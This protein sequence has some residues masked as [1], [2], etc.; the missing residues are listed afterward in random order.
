MLHKECLIKIYII[1]KM[2][3]YAR[4][5]LNKNKEDEATKIEGEIGDLAIDFTM[6]VVKNNA[7]LANAEGDL[8]RFLEE[9]DTFQTLEVLKAKAL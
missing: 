3:K 7:E 4:Y 6:K 1:M 8:E 5:L 2:K 9:M